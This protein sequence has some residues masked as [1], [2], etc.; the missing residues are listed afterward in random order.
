MSK[1]TDTWVMAAVMP[2][3]TMAFDAEARTLDSDTQDFFDPTQIAGP[4]SQ[5]HHAYSTATNIYETAEHEAFL[6]EDD[7]WDVEEFVPDMSA[8]DAALNRLADSATDISIG[9][10][11]H[12]K[13]ID[14]FVKTDGANYVEGVVDSDS[15]YLNLKEVKGDD[16]NMKFMYTPRI[17]GVTDEDTVYVKFHF[18]F[19]ESR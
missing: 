14:N 13:E 3:T 19:G 2:A 18:R 1:V 6:A 9:R 8:A 16:W 5:E 4:E 12:F 17:N 11:L 10:L 15:P 7:G